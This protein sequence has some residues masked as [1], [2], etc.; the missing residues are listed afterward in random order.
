MPR[1]FRR[2][3]EGIFDEKDLIFRTHELAAFLR[4]AAAQYGLTTNDITAVGY[5]NGANV[6]ASL[7]LL[8]PGLLRRAVLWRAMVPLTPQPLPDLSGS[9]VLLLS[10]LQDPILPPEGANRLEQ[11]LQQAGAGI[12]HQRQAAGHGLIPSDLQQA[13]DWISLHAHPASNLPEQSV[14]V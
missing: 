12:T 13:R 4:A 5:S 3:A 11:L 2:L 7:M 8:H 14:I 1:F 10:G 6:A 9:E